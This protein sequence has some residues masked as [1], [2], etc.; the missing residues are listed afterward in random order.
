MTDTV[1]R[2][3]SL[4]DR[5]TTL[6]GEILATGVQALT[7]LPLD[8]MR[9]DRRAGHR[10]ATF[11]SGYQGSPLGG[12]DREL[13]SQRALLDELDVVHRP[14]I[15]EELGATS[16]MGSQ[17]SMTFPRH[18]YDG[19]LG[20]WYGKSPGL[21]RAGDA[22]RHGNYAGTA[23][24]G[25]V[26]ALTGDDPACK[27]STLPSRSDATLAA[28]GLVVLYPGTV[29]DVLDLGLHGVALSRASGLWTALKIVTA[30]AD[31]S[32]TA[33]VDPDRIRPRIPILEVGGKRWAPTL[34]T[35]I[36]T[37]FSLAIETDMLGPRLEMARRYIA[38][39]GL[40]PIVVD[41]PR[42]WLGIIAGG[43]ACEQVLEALA[44][45]GLDREDLSDLGIR[46]LK[47]RRAP[48]LRC[49]GDAPPGR[50]D[51]HGARGRGEGRGA[52]DAGARRALRGARPATGP[53]QA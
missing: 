37:P 9:A 39:N 10:T 28:L 45:L 16:V 53:R 1:V 29:Q 20:I 14:A 31:G 49:R 36:V 21:D 30:V 51:P 12:Y 19:V 41:P 44:T 6:S 26:L 4:G 18:R 35:Q 27:S 11:I 40:N 5:Y 34:T 8:Q 24:L 7:R 22:I 13:Q 48:P 23:P 50:R 3:F 2:Q 33:E 42:P 17:V 25:G 46:I 15:N 32:G 38:D 43:H 52:R 47:L